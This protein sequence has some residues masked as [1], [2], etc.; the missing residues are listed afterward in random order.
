MR[1]G[2]DG[3]LPLP[4]RSVTARRSDAAF[5]SDVGA[6]PIVDRRQCGSAVRV[7][8]APSACFLIAV[9]DGAGMEPSTFL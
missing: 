8:N 2:L 4:S 9:E 7:P 3:S 5:G 1:Y 6:F